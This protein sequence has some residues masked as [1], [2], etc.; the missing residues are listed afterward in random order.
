MTQ[1]ELAARL[2]QNQDTQPQRK[3]A[4]AA[5]R[6]NVPEVQCI[7]RDTEAAG[8]LKCSC[9]Q[10]PVVYAC[11]NPFVFSG[12]CTPSLPTQPGDGPIVR[13][14]GSKV[15]PA[16]SRFPSFLPMPLRDGETPRPCDVVVCA[17]CPHMVEPPPHIKRLRQL[18]IK[19]DYDE[20]GHCDI[21]HVV[22]EPE[23][24]GQHARDWGTCE[25]DGLRSSYIS[26]K[27]PVDLLASADATQCRLVTL[28]A[29]HTDPAAV[30]AL[31]KEFPSLKIWAVLHCPLN[32]LIQAGHQWASYQLKLLRLTKEFDNIWYGLVDP[33]EDFT[34]FGYRYAWWPN[35]AH[36]DIPSS[37]PLLTLPPTLGMGGRDALVKSRPSA[38]YA[39]ALVRKRFL[40]AKLAA[41]I[42][43][44]TNH[45]NDMASAVDMPIS[46]VSYK[47]QAQFRSWIRDSVSVMLEPSMSDSFHY[48]G[49]DA[50]GQGV[51]VVGSQTI[52]YLPR[53]WQAD[54]N[55]PRDIARV[56]M[57]F[58][59]DYPRYSEQALRLGCE[60]RD[61]QRDAYRDAIK[62]ILQ[63]GQ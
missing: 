47:T 52:R 37:P 61:R 28:H 14:D 20:A 51:P 43:G 7:H 34:E 58:L 5:R 30:T 42:K 40:G 16:D 32:V 11:S 38:I 39:A 10:Q 35:T 48:V 44:S 62:R 8:K 55:D 24:W 33:C 12:Y 17:S 29:N 50:I 13:A 1:R 9:S 25:P 53:E 6:G 41:V 49:L 19:G 27:A 31:A 26:H 57:M 3:A 63:D 45:L 18:G 46:V 56:A 23:H 21:L 15:T 22:T 54:P 59:D 60:I 2:N 4:E 36:W